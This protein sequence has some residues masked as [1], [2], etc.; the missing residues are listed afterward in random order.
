MSM[1]DNY[2][3]VT[4]ARKRLALNGIVWTEVWIRMLIKSGRIDSIKMFNSR[5]IPKEEISRIIKE[6]R[7]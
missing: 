3:T 7:R 4:E 2:L 5:V 6:K 1:L